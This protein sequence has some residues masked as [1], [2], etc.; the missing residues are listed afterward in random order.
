MQQLRSDIKK[1]KKRHGFV[2]K[3][4]RIEVAKQAKRLED[5]FSQDTTDVGQ[6]QNS[7]GCEHGKKMVYLLYCIA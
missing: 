1:K 7:Y 4:L 3:N 2:G 6:S 5:D